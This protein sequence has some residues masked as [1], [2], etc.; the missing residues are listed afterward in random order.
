M[1]F[2]EGIAKSIDSMPSSHYTCFSVTYPPG[3]DGSG[4]GSGTSCS[5]QP[6]GKKALV[7]KFNAIAADARKAGLWRSSLSDPGCLATQTHSNDVI[8]TI[9]NQDTLDFAV[10]YQTDACFGAAQANFKSLNIPSPADQWLTQALKQD[11]MFLNRYQLDLL[12]SSADMP[13]RLASA[14]GSAAFEAEIPSLLNYLCST[15]LVFYLP[16]IPVP[17]GYWDGSAWTAEASAIDS[18]SPLTAT[19]APLLNSQSGIDLAADL[20][21]LQTKASQLPSIPAAQT[22]K[23]SDQFIGILRTAEN[24]SL[25]AINQTIDPQV[26]KINATINQQQSSS[27]TIGFTVG[28]GTRFDCTR[29][30]LHLPR[31]W[32]R[33]K[34]EPSFD[35]GCRSHFA[36]LHNS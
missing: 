33:Y 12:P 14:L 19:L 3:P 36:S 21:D 15:G 13:Q 31:S 22:A 9:V 2:L 34:P 8:Q 26:A 23:I 28:I 25:A 1:R 18:T 29:P 27:F 17:Q 16:S 30:F 20:A 5:N 6:T 32:T 4:G 11:P 10:R 24:A 7:D 35:L